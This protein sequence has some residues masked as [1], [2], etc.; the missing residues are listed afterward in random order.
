MF[1]ST[2]QFGAGHEI[3]FDHKIDESGD[4]RHRGASQYAHVDYSRR[5]TPITEI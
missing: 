5:E 3:R 1:V 4:C 2:A